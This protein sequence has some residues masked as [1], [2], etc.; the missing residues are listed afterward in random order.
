MPMFTSRSSLVLHNA[1]TRGQ[2]TSRREGSSRGPTF[3][4]PDPPLL[5][6]IENTFVLHN[7]FL[8]TIVLT[9][10]YRVPSRN[11]KSKY[12]NFKPLQGLNENTFFLIQ[13]VNELTYHLMVSDQ[14]TGETAPLLCF[15]E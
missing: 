4:Y 1:F 15:T 3:S 7:M 10:F 5:L 13:V 9:V 6:Q 14:K 8:G 12:L 11:K 2:R